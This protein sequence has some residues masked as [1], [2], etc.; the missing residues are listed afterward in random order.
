MWSVSFEIYF[1]LFSGALFNIFKR[2]SISSII[3]I[4]I[5][6]LFLIIFLKDQDSIRFFGFLWGIGLAYILNKYSFKS[7]SKKK[8]NILFISILVLIC[9]SIFYRGS[10][11]FNTDLWAR[12]SY[13]LISQLL[14]ALLIGSLYLGSNIFDFILLNKFIVLGGRIS[15]SQYVIHAVIVLPFVFDLAYSKVLDI[16]N[17]P[18]IWFLTLIITYII[19]IFSYMLLEKP[20]MESN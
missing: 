10:I 13:Y 6:S 19:S 7:I 4:F 5:V 12:N 11:W 9:C 14:G 8:L 18:I 20:F 3:L 16:W 17:I 1:Y 15:Y 2:K